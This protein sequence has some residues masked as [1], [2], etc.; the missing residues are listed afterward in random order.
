[1]AGP[2]SCLGKIVLWHEG[3]WGTET[4]AAFTNIQMTVF[5]ISSDEEY[6]IGIVITP[7]NGSFDSDTRDSITNLLLRH[8]YIQHAKIRV[9]QDVELACDVFF[10]LD[11]TAL[12]ADRTIT[13]IIEAYGDLPGKE[14][15]CSSRGGW[16]THYA[17]FKTRKAFD[18]CVKHLGTMYEIDEK[19]TVCSD[20]PGLSLDPPL[21][22]EEFSFRSYD[23]ELYRQTI[24]DMLMEY[25]VPFNVQDNW[26]D[27]V[28]EYGTE[29]V[30]L[31]KSNYEKIPPEIRTV[32]LKLLL[33]LATNGNFDC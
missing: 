5:N 10:V 28:Y 12:G 16:E 17:L 33:W 21:K 31:L 9:H 26:L 14:I 6:T 32:L 20:V 4:T 7:V 15:G 18:D 2:P 13:Q 3:C 25:R 22:L 11:I 19:Q 30:K 29:S 23:F 24:H 8:R 1:M 27:I